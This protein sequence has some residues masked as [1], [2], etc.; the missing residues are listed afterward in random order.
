MEGQ[1]SRTKV[2]RASGK[3]EVQKEAKKEAKKSSAAV[4]VE[5]LENG[6]A[7]LV[8]GDPDES[9]VVLNRE[10]MGSIL[11]AIESVKENGEV[12]GVII[13]G[14]RPDMFCVGADIN[15]I[16]SIDDPVIG[17]ELAREGQDIFNAIASLK[18]PVVAAIG[19]PC[20]GGGCEMALAAK[21]RIISSHPNSLIGLPETRLGIIP[22]FG[23]TQ[24]L[25]RLI[26]LPKALDIILAGKT[27]PP[28]QAYNV[29]LVDKVVKPDSLLEEAQAVILKK[30]RLNPVKL[31]LLDRF[32]TYTS[33]GRAIVSRSVEK[34]LR[35]KRAKFYPALSAAVESCIRGLEKGMKE[36]LKFE[37]KKLGELIV[38]PQCRAL[39]RLFFLT[40]ASKAIGKS[41]KKKVQDVKALVVGAGTMGTGIATV[42]ALNKAKVFLKD[43]S[44]K[45]IERA[46]RRIKSYISQRR[47]LTEAEKAEAIKRVQFIVESS[48]D[49]ST[50]DFVLEAVFED[51]ELKKKVLKEINSLVS[52][53]AVIAS[54]TS[55]LSITELAKA[56]DNPGRVIGMH[57]FN[58]VEKMPLVEIIRGEKTS[59]ST[60]AISAALAQKMGKYPIVV[61]DVPGFL[62]NRILSPYLNEAGYL[63]KDGYAIED[64]DECAESFGM[65][66]GPLKLLDSIGLDV[67]VNVQEILTAAYSGRIEGTDVVKR[68]TASGLNGKKS[69]KGFYDYG[70][71]GQPVVDPKVYSLMGIE[72]RRTLGDKNVVIDRLILALVNEAVRCLDEDVAGKAGQEAANQIDLGTVMGIGFPP[73]R[74]GVIYYAEEL[75]AA[76]VYEKLCFLEKDCGKR[77][78]PWRGIE[79]RAKEKKSFYASLEE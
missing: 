63:L 67:A 41:A 16:N 70:R 77:F 14:P 55:S 8:L 52:R 53:E 11:K 15:I 31:T 43:T 18:V 62:V 24:R 61:K 2:E 29:G 32:L 4:S 7:L 54:N 59:D 27:L 58:P 60:V 23:G 30:S 1:T 44:D 79:K 50:A 72:K 17:E 9:A 12:C 21:H 36:G 38:T 78:K 57:F 20:I 73:F 47:T 22:G 39:V 6:I 65:P 5:V 64:I 51:L 25:P 13:T 37:A 33:L 28:N 45:S 49:L 66:M 48:S 19:G 69:G 71:K 3:K 10:R 75:G 76:K 74:G 26:G 40:E 68:L 42:L 46:R 34:K 35:A 56:V